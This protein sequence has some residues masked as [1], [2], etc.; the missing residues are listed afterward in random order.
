MSSDD[1]LGPIIIEPQGPVA[2]TVLW[3]HGLGADGHDFADAVPF[4][5]VE[6]AGIRFVFPHAPIRPVTVNG[7]M[8]M[9]AWYDI[10]SLENLEREDAAGLS[11]SARLI[12]ELVTIE[13]DRGI[14][15]ERVVVAGF[16]QGGA[17]ALHMALHG[18][19]MASA[20]ALSAYLP[21]TDRGPPQ[22][23]QEGVPV[24]LA[25]GRNDPVIPF[26]LGL[27]A[28]QALVEQGF[29]VTW[30]AHDAGHEVTAEELAALGRWLRQTLG[31]QQG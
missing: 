11:E 30:L 18:Y 9:R 4:L 25:H 26:Q 31:I 5:G 19:S 13:G 27:R 6:G 15:P 28:H 16:S 10:Y 1:A 24:F 7:G 21:L 8:P 22:G 20:V 14:P 12:Q 17:V 23:S 2:A 29:H 3:L